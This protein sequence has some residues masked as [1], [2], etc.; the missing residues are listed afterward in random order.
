[1]LTMRKRISVFSAI[2]FA[3]VSVG[4]AP[5]YAVDQRVIDVVEVTWAGAAAPAANAQGIAKIID[6]EVNSDWLKFTTMPAI[7]NRQ[8]SRPAGISSSGAIAGTAIFGA[9]NAY[10]ACT[11]G[12]DLFVN[13]GSTSIYRFT[14]LYKN[15]DYTDMATANILV[16]I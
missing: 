4:L 7:A 16:K 9:Y 3:I 10:G 14:N 6:T 11:S 15:K 8:S 5:A 1:M 2:V 12:C 13:T